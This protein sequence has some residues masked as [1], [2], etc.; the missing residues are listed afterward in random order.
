MGHLSF[1]DV[2]PPAFGQREYPAWE[3]GVRQAFPEWRSSED[4]VWCFISRVDA[5]AWGAGMHTF[6]LGVSAGC[7]PA[8]VSTG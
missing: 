3:N 2:L 4:A 6:L 8:E 7:L 5:P 1:W